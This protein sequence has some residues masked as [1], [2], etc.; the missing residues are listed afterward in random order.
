MEPAVKFVPGAII[1]R[2]EM[3]TL[4]VHSAKGMA[5]KLFGTAANIMTVEK[6]LSAMLFVFT[7]FD[8]LM[9]PADMLLRDPSMM[10]DVLQAMV[11]Q[12]STS[13]E[14]LGIAVSMEC[15]LRAMSPKE[16]SEVQQGKRDYIK[17]SAHPERQEGILAQCEWCDG[18]RYMVSSIISRGDSLTLSAP[19]GTTQVTP[20]FEYLFKQRIN[21]ILN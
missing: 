3:G 20:R 10:R 11:K 7:R 4:A 16:M 5:H 21:P 19:L 13:G 1:S 15:W 8:C 17:A 2:I 14:V 9:L 18:E 12:V 6:Q